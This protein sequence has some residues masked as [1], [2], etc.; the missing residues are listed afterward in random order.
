MVGVVD[1]CSDLASADD[2]L[3]SDQHQLDGQEGHTFV[4]EVQGAVKDEVPV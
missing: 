4:E 1:A 3:Q 2:L